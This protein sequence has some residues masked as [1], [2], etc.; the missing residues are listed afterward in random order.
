[1][2][3]G[4]F[5]SRALESRLRAAHRRELKRSPELQR[6]FKRNR[7]TESSALG[8]SA[9]Q[10]LMPLFWVGI[11]LMARPK[12]DIRWAASVVALWA[13]GT[14]LKW[15]HQWFQQFY[16]SDSLVVLNFLP[17]DDR[18][19]F[20][21]QLRRYLRGAAWIAWELVLSYMVLFLLR[22]GS[23]PPLTA[24]FLAA[25]AQ[26]VLVLALALH[27]A[28]YLHMLPLGTMAGLF[29][30]T[31]IVLLVLSLRGFE[32]T[33]A[34]VGA[35][36]F[37]LPTGWTNYILLQGSRDW[38]IFALC[39]PIAAIIYLARY[40]FDRLRSYYSLEGFEIVPGPSYPA[41]GEEDELTSASFNHRAGP[42]EIEDRIR[43]RY[44]LEGV[45][46]NLSGALEKFIARFLSPRERIV[47]EFLVAHDPGWTRSLK[48]SFWIWLVA[49]IVVFSFGQFGGIIVFFAAYVLGVASLPIFGGEWK[50]MRQTP[51]GGVFIPG[52]AVYPV[53][54]N[55]IA[56]ILL[57]VNAVRICSAGPFIISFAAL[58]AYR[59]GHSPIIGLIIGSKLLL[60]LLATQP[61]FV[62]LPISSTT[63]ATSRM[64]SV[65]FLVFAPVLLIMVAVIVAVFISGTV[66]GALAACAVLFLLAA[67]LFAT[68]RRA[69]RK[70]K[71]DLLSERAR[72]S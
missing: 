4:F 13:A 50:A 64:A 20:Q 39:I 72:S 16:A 5:A 21:F 61:L 57:K 49:C 27:S 51:T 15:G 10:L 36:E 59:L 62:L 12:L 41:G 22:A 60:V 2:S 3:D 56:G 68:Y 34:F 32:V 48:W 17:L 23:T 18:Q 8:R 1:V 30:M 54:F 38:V 65:W 63:N 14:A 52:Y 33:G 28:S 24:F 40:S 69:Y 31:A 70:G 46:W 35:T 42:T 7:K 11:F 58:A 53:A 45:D 66:F 19:I 44:F 29:R 26:A 47:T 43:A 6:E 67:L 25:M 55:E 9:R 71:F 37:F